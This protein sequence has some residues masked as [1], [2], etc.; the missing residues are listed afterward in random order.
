MNLRISLLIATI[1]LLT[2]TVI[3]GSVYIMWNGEQNQDVPVIV[4]GQT[5]LNDGSDPF[6]ISCEKALM[7]NPS[8][9][10]TFECK[11]TNNTDRNIVTVSVAYSIITTARGGGEIADTFNSLRESALHP[12]FIKSGMHKGIS[13]G[14]AYIIHPIGDTRYKDS[15]IKRVEILVEYVEFD[16]GT[17]LGVNSPAAKRIAEARIGADIY[18]QWLIR[19]FIDNNKNLDV[20]TSLLQPQPLSKEFDFGNSTQRKRGAVLYRTHLLMHVNKKGPDSLNNFLN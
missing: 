1:V 14:D 2:G 13:P 15:V 4:K 10:K 19:K 9:L 12:D 6:I 11:A 17:K 3:A 8:V 5:K 18:K 16:D 7:V 20:I